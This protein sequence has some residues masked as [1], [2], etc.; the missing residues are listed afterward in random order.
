[1]ADEVESASIDGLSIE[2]ARRR[3]L[4]PPEFGEADE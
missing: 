4:I 3:G 2:E 1:L